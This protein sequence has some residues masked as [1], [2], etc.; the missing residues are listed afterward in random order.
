MRQQPR[1]GHQV[2]ISFRLDR[3]LQNV[4]RGAEEFRN[5]FLFQGRSFRRRM[6]AGAEQNFIGVDVPDPGD[7]FLVEQNRFHRAA[8]FCENVFE[9]RKIDTGPIRA[10]ATSFQKLID[11]LT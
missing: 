10:E 6:N 1:L 5:C 3:L 11:I 7:Q 9:F 4:A 8:M 2:H